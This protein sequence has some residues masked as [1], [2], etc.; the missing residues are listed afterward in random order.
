MFIDIETI[1]SVKEIKDLDIRGQELFTKRFQKELDQ[2]Q[3]WQDVW[4]KC[5]ALH[6]EFSRVLCISVGFKNSPKIEKGQ[7]VIPSAEF[8][9]KS[10]AEGDERQLLLKACEILLKQNHLIGHNIKGFDVPFL[11]RRLIV[12]NIPV[13]PVLN[14]LGLKPWEIP[15]SDTQEMWACG[16]FGGKISLD[17]MAYALG[18]P[19]PKTD[20]SG[21]DIAELWYKD[22]DASL[23]RIKKYCEGDVIT[24]ANCYYRIK[25]LPTIKPEEIVNVE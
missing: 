6:A 24:S 19:S 11:L 12:N 14:V 7:E 15:H 16:D 13:P 23:P 20:I 17:R 8:R 2:H 18:L 22:G 4:Q 25:G 3:S 5:A 10:I 21:A 9:V 1:P